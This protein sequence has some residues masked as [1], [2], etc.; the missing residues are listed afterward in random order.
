[1]LPLPTEK[2]RRS[3]GDFLTTKDAARALGVTP[4]RV[5]QLIAA[6]RLPAEKHGRDWL[7][8][9]DALDQVSDRRGPGRPPVD[10]LTAEQYAALGVEVVNDKL[11]IPIL[12]CQKCG[13]TWAGRDWRCPNGCNIGAGD[14]GQEVGE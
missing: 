2:G 13:K 1:M 10:T 8:D 3:M 12:R 14:G 11:R 6:G 9:P 7:I 5:R 4:A